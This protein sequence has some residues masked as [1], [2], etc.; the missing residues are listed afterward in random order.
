ML[1]KF[2]NGWIRK[3]NDGS[4]LHYQFFDVQLSVGDAKELKSQLEAWI[5]EQEFYN[6]MERL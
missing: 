4:C 2:E 1:I 3:N 6:D 5:N